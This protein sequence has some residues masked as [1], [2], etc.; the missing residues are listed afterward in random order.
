MKAFARFLKEFTCGDRQTYDPWRLEQVSI[1]V[2]SIRL[3][4]C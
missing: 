2:A 1:C 3:Q 4:L